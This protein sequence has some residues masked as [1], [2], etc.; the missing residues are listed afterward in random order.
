MHTSSVPAA[1]DSRLVIVSVNWT[2]AL[3]AAHKCSVYNCNRSSFC[4]VAQ[5]RLVILE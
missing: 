4:V 5:P 1:L 3:W 2:S